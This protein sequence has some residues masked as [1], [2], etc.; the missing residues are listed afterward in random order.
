MTKH[1]RHEEPGGAC[2]DKEKHRLTTREDPELL[3]DAMD[4]VVVDAPG[5]SFRTVRE[6]TRHLR[7]RTRFGTVRHVVELSAGIVERRCEPFRL[8]ISLAL[9]L[10]TDVVRDVGRLLLGF[11]RHRRRMLNGRV[12][13][14]VSLVDGLILD[15]RRLALRPAVV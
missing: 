13:E 15:L 11:L 10:P 3:T 5:K 1:A 12:L 8:R 6:L 14:L 2:S 9:E 4:A 7:Q